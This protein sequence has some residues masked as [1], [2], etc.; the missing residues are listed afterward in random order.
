ME[1]LSIKGFTK[2]SQD[3]KR[4]VLARKW[5]GYLGY[6]LPL[7]F[8]LVSLQTLSFS[9]AAGLTIAVPLIYLG[10]SGLLNNVMYTFDETGIK[11]QNKP[12]PW[13]LPADRFIAIDAIKETYLRELITKNKQSGTRS[14]VLIEVRIKLNQGNELTI[15]SFGGNTSQDYENA[16]L[17]G[18][19]IKRYL[20]K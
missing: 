16:T 9:F 3:G 15:K 17:V 18:N 4:L 2:V 7:S 11:I 10:I 14:G 20:K 5:G 8:G 6:L 1:N 19:L 13:F 12:I